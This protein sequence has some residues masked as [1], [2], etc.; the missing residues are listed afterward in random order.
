MQGFIEKTR[1]EWFS[2][3]KRTI[4]DHPSRR[5]L[6]VK[7][8]NTKRPMGRPRLRY[9]YQVVEDSKAGGIE[10]ETLNS[11]RSWENRDVRRRLIRKTQ[12][13][14]NMKQ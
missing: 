12:N 7:I 8:R 13:D 3:L 14:G 4:T 1:L 6:E 11:E 10:W 9:L 2:H 5:E